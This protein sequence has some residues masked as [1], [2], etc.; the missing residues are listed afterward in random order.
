MNHVFIGLGSNAGNRKENLE[1]AIAV[2]GL[3]MEVIK[4]SDVYETKAEN[5]QPGHDFPFLNAVMSVKTELTAKEVLNI[6]L[7]TEEKT[8]R[9]RKEITGYF[10]RE[11]DLDLLLFNDEI[12]F[13]NN[14]II[15]HPRMHERWFVLKPLHDIAPEIFIP[16]SGKKVAEFLTECEQKVQN[17]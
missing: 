7:E 10:S 11:I 17:L 15:P 12:I 3:T 13:E 1:M 6:L 14:L 2:I 4:V 8:G 5:M 9:K 16:G